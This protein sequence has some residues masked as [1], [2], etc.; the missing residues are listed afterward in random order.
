[1][2]TSISRWRLYLVLALIL[3]AIQPATQAIGGKDPAR[4]IIVAAISFAIS[5]LAAW[6]IVGRL[7]HLTI[8][9]VILISIWLLP[10]IV[11]ASVGLLMM[12]TLADLPVT[13]YIVISLFR[14]MHPANRA[15]L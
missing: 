4:H 8:K 1:M 6:F 13:T 15:S 9:P 12:S 7:A 14:I 3:L 10:P 2:N 5:G 11:L